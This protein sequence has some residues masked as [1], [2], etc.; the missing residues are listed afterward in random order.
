MRV[1][2]FDFTA[3]KSRSG[4]NR[5]AAEVRYDYGFGPEGPAWC[6]LPIAARANSGPIRPEMGRVMPWRATR[7]YGFARRCGRTCGFTT[8]AAQPSV[9]QFRTVVQTSSRTACQLSSE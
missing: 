2:G 3:L 9:Y 5:E 4:A 1:V 8:L 6:A 7:R